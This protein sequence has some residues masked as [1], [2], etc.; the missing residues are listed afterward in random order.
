MPPERDQSTNPTGRQKSCARCVKSKRRCD[1]TQPSCL[2][3]TRQHFTCSYPSRPAFNAIPVA[4]DNSPMPDSSIDN[5]ASPF[6]M[7]LIQG[8]RNT[9]VQSRQ[10]T[11]LLDLDVNAG[12]ESIGILH[13]LRNTSPMPENQ[14]TIIRS[15][16]VPQAGECRWEL[17][18]SSYARISY[19]IDRMKQA[20]ATMVLENQTPWSHP[21]LYEDCMPRVLQEAHATCALYLARNETNSA[22]FARH[23]IDR[24]KELTSSPPPTAPLDILARAHALILYQAINAFSG[25]LQLNA[26]V[27]PTFPHLEESIY[28]LYASLQS[29]ETPPSPTLISLYPA[30]TA[31]QA[32]RAFILRESSQR[33]L[34]ILCQFMILLHLLQ[35]RSY[36]FDHACVTSK[37]TTSA[38]LWNAGSTIEFAS[39]W[40]EKRHFLV[41]DL[42]FSEVLEGAGPED[43]DV[44]GRM[45]LVTILGRDDM[46]GWFAERGGVF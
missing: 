9:S 38:H 36:C 5:V 2:R 4:E 46:L 16:R 27:C 20:P 41:A 25:D 3:C 10:D 28:A 39:A 29:S 1:L 24:V 8:H 15:I 45:I 44:F 14:Q 18:P 33:T 11:C 26:H 40:N 13:D 6:D 22:F 32:W 12:L 19:A 43:I 30:T 7:S 37:I 23:V 35:G 31:R 42:D 34:L 21:L 17:T